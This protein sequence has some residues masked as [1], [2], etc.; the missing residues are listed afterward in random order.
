[1]RAGSRRTK[2]RRIGN[3]ARK[4][5]QA[6]T[7][8]V[9]E[10]ERLQSALGTRYRIERKLARGG[11]ATVYVATELHPHRT[12]AIKVFDPAVSVRVGEERFQREIAL[13][14]KLTHPGI[15]SVYTAGEVDGLLYYVMPFVEGETL[16][17]RLDRE[18]QLSLDDVAL[19]VR[20]V[21]DALD[22]AHRRNIVHRDIKPHNILLHEGRAFVADFGIAKAVYDQDPHALTEDGLAVGTAEYMSPEQIHGS[23]P[24]DA[25]CDV[26]SLGCVIY[27]MLTGEPP[28]R[29]RTIQSVISRQLSDT[30]SPMRILRQTIPADLDKVVARA[31]AKSPSDRF[32]SVVDL[33]SAVIQ[34]I[35]PAAVIRF[36]TPTGRT[37]QSISTVDIVRRR[38]R[39]FLWAGGAAL[40]IVVGAAG[41]L[42]VSHSTSSRASPVAIATLTPTPIRIA[43]RAVDNLTG[44]PVYEMAVDLLTADLI[45]QL[46]D[47][48]DIEVKDRSSSVAL[49][50][51]KL[52]TRQFAESLEV[53]HVIESDLEMNADALVLKAFL[54]DSTGRILR[55]ARAEWRARDFGLMRVRDSVVRALIEQLATG[56]PQSVTLPRTGR[57]EHLAGHD[58]LLNGS[59]QLATRTVNG[60]RSAI[61]EFDAAI[62]I[63]PEYAEAYA[64]LSK[65]YS[66]ALGYR[67][68][69]GI[70][71]YD[72]AG[73]S[74]AAADR[75]IR[76]E[77][78]LASGYSARGYIQRLTIAPVIAAE[79]SLDSAKRLDPDAADAVGWSAPALAMQGRLQEAISEAHR[80]IRL[81]KLSASRRITLAVVSVAARRYD[82]AARSAAAALVLVPELGLAKAWWAR[83]L[84]LAGRGAECADMVPGP[85]AGLKA[86]CL[87]AAGRSA[88]AASVIDSLGREAAV[89][90]LTDSTFTDV[91]R[92]EDLATYYAYAGEAKQAALWADRAYD[93]APNG[94]APELLESELFAPVRSDPKFQTVIERARRR[95][96]ERVELARKTAAKRLEF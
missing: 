36:H 19:I 70:D 87:R 8:P 28:F 18:H 15:V 56:L 37:P 69:L 85:Y 24:L 6:T 90:H 9:S 95:A 12:V 32:A 23:G 51:S 63:D 46:H 75:A 62:A 92:L 80:A 11:M 31:L 47:L 1:M 57:H 35:D 44:S 45:N 38:R 82:E 10:L 94:I 27:E 55:P 89:N 66:L 88:E 86:V 79:A 67:Y 30:A 91:V 60:L 25:R 61:T 48:S 52:T 96:T 14:G 40:T 74:L 26:Y 54:A 84:V 41:A 22:H 53:T 58:H 64:E 33:A 72:A 20:D 13:A 21:A 17:D 77:P 43:V 59:R 71:P 76:L 83:A 34:T 68:R 3:A 39:R 29:G 5:P 16:R 2:I 50:E 73:R 93:R 78:R 42:A 81:D 4:S 65:A 7:A 49:R